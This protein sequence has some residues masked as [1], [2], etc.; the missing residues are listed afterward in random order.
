MRRT[1]AAVALSTTALIFSQPLYGAADDVPGS[2]AKPTLDRFGD[3]L[4]PG[5]TSRL[6]TTRLR[7][8]E[9]PFV[10]AFS[11]DGHSVVSGGWNGPCRFWDVKTGKL[12]Q[13][14]PDDRQGCF[15]IAF[16]PDGMHLVGVGEDIKLWDVRTGKQLFKIKS[17][18]GR[19]SSVAF[20]P[21]G[22]SFATV[23][24]IRVQFWALQ[25][26][27]P[28]RTIDLSRFP[29]SH[30]DVVAISPDGERSRS[31]AL[32]VGWRFAAHPATVH[33]Y[34]SAEIRATALLG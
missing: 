21:D 16:S 1:V 32:V 20:T 4:P 9:G 33:Q 3:P 22:K 11:P 15:G 24:P 13:T 17:S 10:V 31:A 14:L 12:Q 6:G 18:T 27:G 8:R 28:I 26:N 34:L 23:A 19:L 5:A 25:G 30:S 7:Q 29:G 2:E